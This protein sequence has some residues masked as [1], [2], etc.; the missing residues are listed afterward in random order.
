MNEGNDNYEYFILDN[1]PGWEIKRYKDTSACLKAVSD[2]EADCIIISN[3]RYNNI[4]KQC[5]KLKLGTV[6]TGISMKYCFAVN[7]SE[8]D[9][10]S[11]LSRIAVVVPESVVNAS[12]AYYSSED[13]KT[14]FA[15]FVRENL[16]AIV[17]GVAVIAFVRNIEH[18]EK[19]MCLVELIIDIAK[20][21]QIPVI[22]EG[23]ETEEQMVMLKKAGCALVQGF[24]FSRPLSAADFEARILGS[25]GK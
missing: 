9:L 7:E 18:S 10:Y 21:L 24:Y 1:Y 3:Y 20:N 19:D 15:D 16:A 4:S 17:A 2:G 6:M 11:I 25:D 12:L 23:V 5:E 8:T 22:A 14:D 13:A